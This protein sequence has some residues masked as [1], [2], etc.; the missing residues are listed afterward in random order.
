MQDVFN[1]IRVSDA[2]IKLN[3]E[4]ILRANRKRIKNQNGTKI[5]ADALNG[6]ALKY[7][8][9]DYQVDGM[10]HLA[11]S[12]RAMLTDEMGLG[13]TV[14]AVAAA[15]IMQEY[16]GVKRVMVVCPASLKTEWEEQIAKF[17][18]LKTHVVF[19]SSKKE[20]KYIPKYRCF[21]C[22]NKL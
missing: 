10:F 18:D 2:V 3:N 11:F 14:Q 20:I 19:G 12:G 21:L 9:Y 5:K 7:P 13:K 17:T 16:L 1:H 15:A 22:F 8:L 6:E 4:N